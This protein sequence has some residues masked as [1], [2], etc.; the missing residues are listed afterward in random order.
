MEPPKGL[1]EG[2]KFHRY[3]LDAISWMKSIENNVDKEFKYCD[4]VPWRASRTSLLFD[5]HNEKIVLPDKADEYIGS[6]KSKG[7]VLADV[8][9]LGKTVECK[10]HRTLHVVLT[11]PYP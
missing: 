10:R 11:L 7:G 2:F 9:G 1:K 8:V 3:Q 6:L 4:L 5:L